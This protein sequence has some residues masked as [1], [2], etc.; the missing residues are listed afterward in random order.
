M[1]VLKTTLV[2]L[3]GM[4]ALSVSAGDLTTE[5]QAKFLKVIVS[6]SGVGK[7][8]CS[9]AALKSA[10]EA[11]GVT[12][13]AGAPIAWASNALEAKNLKTAGRL[14]ISGRHELLNA[15]GI[16]IEEQGGRP[17]ILLNSANLNAAKVQVG[18]AILKIGEKM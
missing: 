18:D 6:S 5:A 1:K 17:K 14:V 12:V 8:A 9:D 13:D 7:I 15:A 4:A 3:L 2:A 11:Q 10:L 16:V